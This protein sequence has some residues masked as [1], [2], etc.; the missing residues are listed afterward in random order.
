MTTATTAL[1]PLVFAPVYK[2]FIWGGDRIIRRYNRLAPLGIYAESWEISDRSEGMSLVV[3]GPLA[4][5][6]LHAL[7]QSYGTYLLGTAAASGRFPLLTKILDARERLSVQ[8]HPD[9]E[10]AQKVGGEP[11]TEIWY[12]LDADPGA[13]VFA[14]LKPGTTAEHFRRALQ[15]GA[16]TDLLNAIPVL[17]GDV[18]S[19]PGG[20][21]HAIGAGCLM[22]EVQQNSD[23]TYRVFDWN[24]LGHDGKPR[25]LHVD[26]A[27]EVM[28][29]NDAV[30]ARLPAPAGA[31]DEGIVYERFVSPYFRLD[32][33]TVRAP[34]ACATGERSFHILFI[35]EGA[36][37]V[38]A[39][40]MTV[41]AGPGMTL[42][43][44][45][46]LGVYEIAGADGGSGRVIRIRLP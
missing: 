9:D 25:E 27:L 13:L 1:Y 19:I 5:R 22:L 3:N 44:P 8:V 4:G 33:V 21:V 30:P 11:K 20:R 39:S 42:L 36:V 32:Q 2:D 46:A 40:G 16:V 35:E 28:R 41:A 31:A 18:V 45:A 38:T 24:R 37:N 7:V 14:G 23:T 15:T 26:R 17:A 12:V 34:L 6:S 10:S 29:W 43:I